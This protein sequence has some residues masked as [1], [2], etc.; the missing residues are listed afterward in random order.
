[1]PVKKYYCGTSDQF[2]TYHTWA[3]HPDRANIPDGGRVNFVDGTLAPEKQKTIVY[4]TKTEHPSNGLFIWL[5][6]DYKNDSL[7]LTEYTEDE[8]ISNGYL[9]ELET[10]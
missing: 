1:M 6:G 9:P 5:F 7:A 3:C 10:N 4:T 8:A 2:D